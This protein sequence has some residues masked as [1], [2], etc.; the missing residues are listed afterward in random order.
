MIHSSDVE[1]G[2]YYVLRSGRI[3]KALNVHSGNIRIEG[4]FGIG[5][6]VSA[7][8]KKKITRE[9]NPEYFL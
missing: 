1:E 3:A 9:E 2:E 6:I 8:L 7:D 5:W 4:Q